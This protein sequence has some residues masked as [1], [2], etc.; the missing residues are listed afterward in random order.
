[1]SDLV[2]AETLAR[3][4]TNQVLSFELYRQVKL[5]TLTSKS[6]K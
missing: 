6:L 4:M 3:V 5:M 1:M 2:R